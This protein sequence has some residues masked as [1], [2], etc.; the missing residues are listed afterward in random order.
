MFHDR[1][2]NNKISRIHEQSLRIVYGNNKSSFKE[3]FRK[4]KSAKMH[5]KNLQV[6]ATE[7]C[8]VTHGL[9]SR[10]I[11]NVFELKSVSYNMRRQ[12][13]FGSR[14]YFNPSGPKIWDIVSQV[15]KN[16]EFLS[17]FK[18]KIKQWAPINC[19]CRLYRPYLQYAGYISIFLIFNQQIT[20]N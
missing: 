7:I 13:L 6:F 9:S 11:N 4:D 19:S 16:S 5:Y 1:G 12:D 15:I 17:V 10:I 14:R 2:R 8:K 3:L 18:T 20:V